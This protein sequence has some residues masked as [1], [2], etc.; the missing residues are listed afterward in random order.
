[1]RTFCTSLESVV[2]GQSNFA[3]SGNEKVQDGGEF[4]WGD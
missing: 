3:G 4:D 1:M 2:M